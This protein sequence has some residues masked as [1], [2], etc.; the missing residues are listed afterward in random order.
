[1]R[2]IR[3]LVADGGR[4]RFIDRVKG[5]AAYRTVSALDSAHLH[6]KERDLGR[7]RPARVQESVGPMRHGIEPKSDLKERAKREFL[8]EVESELDAMADRGEFD[9][10]VV[11][12]PARSLSALRER[13]AAGIAARVIAEVDADLTN[14]PDERMAEHL[15]DKVPALRR[16]AV[17]LRAARG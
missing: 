2:T 6:A 4:A 3:V 11:V 1:M 7:D 15:D 16:Y 10:V 8:A 17:A 9:E 12:A 5:T 13:R 14:T